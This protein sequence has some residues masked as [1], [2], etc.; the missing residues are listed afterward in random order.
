MTLSQHLDRT[1]WWTH[2]IL[3][4]SDSE[5]VMDVTPHRS[6]RVL[7]KPRVMS[8]SETTSTQTWIHIDTYSVSSSSDSEASQAIAVGTASES[9]VEAPAPRLLAFEQARLQNVVRNKQIER[10]IAQRFPLD[11]IL[12]SAPLLS[13]LPHILLVH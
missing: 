3:S 6:V 13:G 9:E 10:N 11:V 4:D 12:T 1:P 5:E 7:N 2:T 8:R